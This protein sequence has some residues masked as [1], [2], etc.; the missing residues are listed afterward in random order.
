MIVKICGLQTIEHAQ[1]AAEAGADLLGFNFAASKR[2][3]TPEQA[4]SIIAAVRAN[5]GAPRMVG[6]FVN[7][8]LERI[9]HICDR[10]GLDAIQL[11]GDEPTTMVGALPPLPLFKAI[12]FTDD[13]REQAWL[14]LDR[15]QVTLLVDAHVQGSYG[16]TGTTANWQAAA[17]LGRNRPILLAGG[18]NPANV[19][20]AIAQVQP[21]GVDVSSGVERNGQKDPDLIRHF[22]AAAH[23]ASTVGVVG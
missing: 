13:Q 11:S 15:S 16:G 1:V 18:L 20:A 19:G 22:V 14:M 4:A 23:D 9:A 8:T 7:E 10:C 21:W 5:G 12:R 2:Q 17:E 6:L 3:V